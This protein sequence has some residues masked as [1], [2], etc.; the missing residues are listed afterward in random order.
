MSRRLLMVT[1]V[2]R[3]VKCYELSLLYRRVG[4]KACKKSFLGLGSPICVLWY[5]ASKEAGLTYSTGEALI[6]VS[7]REIAAIVFCNI[8]SFSIFL[9]F[10]SEVVSPQAVFLLTKLFRRAKECPIFQI[11][12]SFSLMQ[13][14][15]SYLISV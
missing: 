9:A 11:F 3:H 10:L 13:P 8:F 12:L 4:L 15:L 2:N 7:L 14:Y 6:L 1:K 5:G